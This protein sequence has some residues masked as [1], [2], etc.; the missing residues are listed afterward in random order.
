MQGSLLFFQSSNN[1]SACLACFLFPCISIDCFPIPKDRR[2]AQQTKLLKERN[3]SLLRAVATVKQN[4]SSSTVFVSGTTEECVLINLFMPPV[5][6]NSTP[7]SNP[8]RQ[9]YITSLESQIS[10]LR[11]ELATVY[12]TQGQNAQ[13]LLAMNETLRE[14]E[15]LARIESEALRKAREDISHL[16]RKVDQHAELMGEKDRT[17]QV[18]L[19]TFRSIILS[20]TTECRSYTTRSVLCNSSWVK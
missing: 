14:K 18:R 15:E 12:K 5:L 2:L 17:A 9:A 13:R 8:V 4:P 6:L 19:R 3:A 11:D 7:H 10:S 20:H 16:K 1:V